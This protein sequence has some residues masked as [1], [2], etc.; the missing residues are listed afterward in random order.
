MAGRQADRQVGRKVE[1]RNRKNKA[2]RTRECEPV[3]IIIR[4][5]LNFLH[6]PLLIL[7]G[8]AWWYENAKVS[9]YN[10]GWPINQHHIC[11]GQ[12]TVGGRPYSIE[13]GNVFGVT[14]FVQTIFKRIMKRKLNMTW[15]QSNILD[16]LNTL[17]QFHGQLY[18]SSL[19]ATNEES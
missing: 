5:A 14:F 2:C 3:G 6:F 16:P 12:S 17:S 4:C 7:L 10:F 8:P 18:Y 13:H 15:L 19:L 1:A 9:H 11:H